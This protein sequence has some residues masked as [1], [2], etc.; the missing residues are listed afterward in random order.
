[1]NEDYAKWL[2]EDNAIGILNMQKKQIASVMGITRPTLDRYLLDYN[3][4]RQGHL[5]KLYEHIKLQKA[6]LLITG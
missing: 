4:V 2:I 6:R 5:N 3:K 1:M